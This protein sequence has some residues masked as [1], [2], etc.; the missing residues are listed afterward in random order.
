[1]I[2]ILESYIGMFSTSKKYSCNRIEWNYTE[3]EPISDAGV[4]RTIPRK[5][6]KHLA[7]ETLHLSISL[8][9]VF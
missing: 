1:M 8:Y 3:G 5:T 7:T 6:L 9:P 2:L 4:V